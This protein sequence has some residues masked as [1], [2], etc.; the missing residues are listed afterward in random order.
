MPQI[1]TPGRWE[2][3]ARH[4]RLVALADKVRPHIL[5]VLYEVSQHGSQP[6]LFGLARQVPL[7]AHEQARLHRS[8]RMLRGGGDGDGDGDDGAGRVTELSSEDVEAYNKTFDEFARELAKKYGAR[9]TLGHANDQLPMYRDKNGQ[10]VVKYSLRAA[11]PRGQRDR[12][13]RSAFEYTWEGPRLSENDEDLGQLRQHMLASLCRSVPQDGQAAEVTRATTIAGDILRCV[14]QRAEDGG[15]GDEPKTETV[16]L[17]LS[18]V[19]G[20]T[21]GGDDDLTLPS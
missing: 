7:T 1:V 9:L 13:R 16:T 14:Y 12:R 6:H 8:L 4:N 19:G 15:E 21:G 20:D 11:A 3:F 17:D 10:P 18:P 5:R 2:A